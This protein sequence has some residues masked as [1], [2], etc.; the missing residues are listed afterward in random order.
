MAKAFASMVPP[1]DLMKTESGTL[2][3]AAGTAIPN[4]SRI[5]LFCPECAALKLKVPAA[6]APVP[7][8]LALAVVTVLQAMMPPFRFT[9]PWLD[10]PPTRR[11]QSA[12][13]PDSSRERNR[14]LRQ[15][16]PRRGWRQ[17]AAR[18]GEPVEF[19]DLKRPAIHGRVLILAT[20]PL[21]C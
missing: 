16:C 18:R 19:A 2:T 17:T 12:K 9:T 13:R 10:T 14:R 7:F 6:P 20:A 3:L 1:P 11:Q 8:T 15:A 21:A 4:K 5:I